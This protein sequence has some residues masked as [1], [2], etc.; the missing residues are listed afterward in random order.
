L[1]NSGK[2]LLV[3]ECERIVRD[4]HPDSAANDG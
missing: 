1:H 4:R 2:K 3:N